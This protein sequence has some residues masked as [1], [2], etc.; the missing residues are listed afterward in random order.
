MFC[1]SNYHKSGW[2]PLFCSNLLSHFI[3]FQRF[4]D[5]PLWR[6][7]H[8]ILKPY[9]LWN[10]IF[11][12]LALS[13]SSVTIWFWPISQIWPCPY[14]L[15]Q[16]ARRLSLSDGDLAVC[17]RMLSQAISCL[18]KN[19]TPYHDGGNGII[20]CPGLHC[21]GFMTIKGTGHFHLGFLGKTHKRI[22]F[23]PFFFGLTEP[24]FLC[25]IEDQNMTLT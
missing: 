15:W 5:N 9:L 16:F 18:L 14:V 1:D 10:C 13:L 20:S 12:D 4:C 23:L 6:V 24:R 19:Y 2:Y 3:T 25:I 8:S 17:D 7:S 21:K 22:G 11:T